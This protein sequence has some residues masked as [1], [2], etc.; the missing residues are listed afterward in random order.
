MIFIFLLV[1]QNI[2]LNKYTHKL[3]SIFIII[4]PCCLYS[5]MLGDQWLYVLININFFL[6]ISL[7]T[8]YVSK[9][10]YNN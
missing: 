4:N 10:I 6:D 9:I 3:K 2:Y 1:D 8:V 7:A 5:R